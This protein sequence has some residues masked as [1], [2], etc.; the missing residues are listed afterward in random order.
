MKRKLTWMCIFIL[1]INNICS[2]GVKSA[3][4]E[5]AV[6][7]QEVESGAADNEAA[8]TEGA[9]SEAP[10]EK[11]NEPEDKTS[12]EGEVEV[13]NGDNDREADTTNNI[14]ETGINNE[15]AAAA[16]GGTK[17]ETDTMSEVDAVAEA[18]TVTGNSQEPSEAEHNII[19]ASDNVVSE[20]SV[21]RDDVVKMTVETERESTSDNVESGTIPIK[22]VDEDIIS[23][24]FPSYTEEDD[25]YDFILDPLGMINQTGAARYGG[26][27]FQEGATVY[28]K[29]Q[30]NPEVGPVYTNTSDFRN[31]V[32]KS[33][34]PV[35]V[36]VIVNF[37]NEGEIRVSEDPDFENL[38]APAVSFGIVDEAGETV[39][40]NL[41]G[42]ARLVR[43]L[44]AAPDDTY[45]YIYDEEE[46]RYRLKTNFEDVEFDE[47]SF[48]IWGAANPNGDWENVTDIPGLEV[49][50][51]V[52]PILDEK[53]EESETAGDEESTS[54]SEESAPE[55]EETVPTE[56]GEEQSTESKAEGT[57]EEP[58]DGGEGSA[59][60]NAES[61]SGNEGDAAVEEKEVAVQSEAEES[62]GEEEGQNESASE[63]PDISFNQAEADAETSAGEENKEQTTETEPK[64]SETKA[65]TAP[66]PDG[67]APVEGA[68]KEENEEAEAGP[69]KVGKGRLEGTVDRDIFST[70]LPLQTEG[71]FRFIMDPE[72]L[73][74]RTNGAAYPGQKMEMGQTL[75]FHNTSVGS[76]YNY[77]STSD[78]ITIVNNGTVP[79]RISVS[80]SL[81]GTDSVVISASSN[82]ADAPYSHLY[83]AFVD[84][85]GDIVSTSDTS[86]RTI[87]A[88]VILKGVSSNDYVLRWS[89]EKQDY[90]YVLPENI[91]PTLVPRFSFYLQGASNPNAD[92]KQ[93]VK[94][95]PKIQV[96]WKVEPLE[97]Y[98]EVEE[99]KTPDRGMKLF[100]KMMQGRRQ[101]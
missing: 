95:P 20:G 81:L 83:F 66:E 101:V 77:S 99:L 1:A 48:G 31:I 93:V 88:D 41:E 34:V 87:S 100:L 89:D 85:K 69:E 22:K 37:S 30:P 59:S 78:P 8:T 64:I 50:W 19:S 14:E 60:E 23:V 92:W 29:N 2:F 47:F 18:N 82:F 33:N 72:K 71:K 4:A 21:S 76:K 24:T 52:E 73:I 90:E 62:K 16:E 6:S 27:N 26:G 54:V 65:E 40:M 51:S 39:S 11:E 67:D 63:S 38:D 36:S 74:T 49:M 84:A 15:E 68:D 13:Q 98:E 94:D 17:T 70:R 58:S 75:Y 53:S 46:G 3:F 25:I 42:E 43:R 97:P 44:E 35:E 57:A 56:E 7:V 32:N 5:E 28:F 45:V 79:V 61:L 96:V 91:D 12:G 80:A 86:T 10:A 9:G 55:N